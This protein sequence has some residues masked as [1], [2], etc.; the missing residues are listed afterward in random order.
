MQVR[1]IA[2]VEIRAWAE[3]AFQHSRHV[4]V[5]ERFGL[6]MHDEQNGG[7]RVLTDALDL[8]EFQSRGWHRAAVRVH[9]VCYARE[10]ASSELPQPERFEQRPQLTRGGTRKRG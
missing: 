5:Q 4:R 3:V 1:V 8:L 9:G 10:D 7:R 2:D 6:T